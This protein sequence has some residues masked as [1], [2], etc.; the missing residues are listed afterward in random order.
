MT[1][2]WATNVYFLKQIIR[3]VWR[4]ANGRIF[5]LRKQKNMSWRDGC[6]AHAH[7]RDGRLAPNDWTR[8]KICWKRFEWT[9]I[10]KRLPNDGSTQL[11][12]SLRSMYDR[13]GL[14]RYA[15]FV[16]SYIFRKPTQLKCGRG[17]VSRVIA[18]IA[19][20]RAQ[21]VGNMSH[22]SLILY[23]LHHRLVV[24]FGGHVH[25]AKAKL[26]ERRCGARGAMLFRDFFGFREFPIARG[27]CEHIAHCM[28]SQNSVHGA[29]R[30]VIKSLIKTDDIIVIFI[31]M[32]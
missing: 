8:S 14:R 31:H 20:E 10:F 9:I 32:F 6:S 1:Y 30:S 24:L 19:L 4:V 21:A 7:S 27:V 12:G 29:R 13:M 25:Y 23:W 16:H 2:R 18:W 17:L 5:R 3:G 28:Y 22:I 11:A 26:F 15:A